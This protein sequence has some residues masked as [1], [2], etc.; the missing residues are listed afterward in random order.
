MEWASAGAATGV[1]SLFMQIVG[2]TL[3]AYKNGTSYLS[4]ADSGSPIASG[5]PGIFMSGNYVAGNGLINFQADNVVAAVKPKSQAF[6][7]GL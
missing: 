2:G 1:P 4:A 5:S 7:L 6:I 3:T